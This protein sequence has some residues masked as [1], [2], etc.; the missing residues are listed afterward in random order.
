MEAD[1]ESISSVS[2]ARDQKPENRQSK[3][4]LRRLANLRTEL[5]VPYIIL[6]L[7][8]AMV[9]TFVVTR[10]VTAS[11]RERFVNHMVEASRVA[12]D[13]VVRQ[14]QRN[15]S[16]LRLLVFTEGVSSALSQRDAA[17]LQQLLLPLA[18]N[19]HSELITAI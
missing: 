3:R 1:L 10:L 5:I 4:W 14:E 12:A 8:I 9:G 6:T 16:M 2:D 19:N 7:L 11:I 18:L 13:G 15:L 17:A